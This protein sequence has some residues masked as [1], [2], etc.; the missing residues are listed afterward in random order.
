MSVVSLAVEGNSNLTAFRSLRTLRALRPLRA[1][2]RWQGMKVMLPMLLVMMV[3]VMLPMLVVL[4]FYYNPLYYKWTKLA[5][6]KCRPLSVWLL[7]FHHE[8]IVI[9]PL[10]FLCSEVALTAF[11]ANLLFPPNDVTCPAQQVQTTSSFCIFFGNEHLKYEENWVQQRTYL[12]W[13]A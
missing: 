11:S 1:I 9:F 6:F 3:V 12:Y 10:A 2:S 7:F 4:S 13:G 8:A 5:I